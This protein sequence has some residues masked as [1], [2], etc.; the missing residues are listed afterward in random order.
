[1]VELTRLFDSKG[2]T[3]I[4]AVLCA[5]LVSLSVSTGFALAEDVPSE[6]Q[7]VEAEPII[8]DDADQAADAA[9]ESE[10]DADAAD[11]E[12]TMGTDTESDQTTD[13]AADSNPAASE[14]QPA[15]VTPAADPEIDQEE[16]VLEA[17][18][19]AAVKSVS[20]KPRAKVQIQQGVYWTQDASTGKQWLDSWCA[21]SGGT[22]TVTYTDGKTKEFTYEDDSKAL[23]SGSE[24]L[25]LNKGYKLSFNLKAKTVSIE[26]GGKSTSF[27]VQFI[28][29]IQSS[30]KITGVKDLTYTGAALKQ[31]GYTV[32]NIYTGATL[33]EGTDY[34]VSYNTY[35]KTTGPN[36]KKVAAS[37]LKKPGSYKLLITGTG[38]AASGSVLNGPYQSGKIYC[39]GQ[40]ADFKIVVKKPTWSGPDRLPEGSEGEYKVTN[41]GWIRMK[42]SDGSRTTSS[43]TLD[44]WS[45]S[46]TT[47]LVDAGRAGTT[48]LYLYDG[49]GKQVASKK[50]TVYSIKD[51][52][53]EIQSAVNSN[54]V[55]DIRGK[56]KA[57]SA[58]MIVWPRNNGKNQ[59]YR[60]VYHHFGSYDKYALYNIQCVHSGKYVDV[61][62]GGTKKS[63]PVIQYTPKK[64]NNDNQLWEIKVDAKNRVTFV[65]LNSGMVFDIQGGK[66]TKRAQMIQYPFNG[67][68]NQKWILNKK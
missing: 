26:V 10:Q 43:L 59:R 65:N 23:T 42:D 22:L 20:F 58:R 1:M 27:P 25:A 31:K 15:E 37:D 48:T 54:Y 55:L 61:Q 4:L 21:L 40:G 46:E 13:A 8:D 47:K 44:I 32:K 57:N 56:S 33:K 67:G 30:T 9:A 6:Q 2:R 36:G 53:F 34:T 45:I 11:S 7:A 68:N 29:N 52:E 3:R 35:S 18:A 66:V 38:K 16:V 39:G 49:N 50:V 63:Q 24:K 14:L 62:G 64:T 17:Q 51:A 5:L 60:F 19:S 41:G 28:Y 12:Q